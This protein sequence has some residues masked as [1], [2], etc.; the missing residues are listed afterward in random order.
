MHPWLFG[1]TNTYTYDG[2]RVHVWPI[3]NIANY[4]IVWAHAFHSIC[5]SIL[6]GRVESLILSLSH[7]LF[8]QVAGS[9]V[10]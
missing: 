2:V 1:T 8:R 10:S 6:F 7:S 4:F 9:W 5:R 3:R